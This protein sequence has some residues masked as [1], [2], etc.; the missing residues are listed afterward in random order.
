MIFWQHNNVFIAP[1]EINDLRYRRPDNKYW[2]M[3]STNKED[4]LPNFWVKWKKETGLDY[5]RTLPTQPRRQMR[6]IINRVQG[7][8]RPDAYSEKKEQDARE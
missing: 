1:P 6:G 4:A 2:E 5:P 8:R 3:K 7:T